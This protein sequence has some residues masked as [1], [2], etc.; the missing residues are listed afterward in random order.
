[1]GQARVAAALGQ[2]CL[3]QQEDAPGTRLAC[4]DGRLEGRSAPADHHDIGPLPGRGG[5]TYLMA[6]RHF[7]NRRSAIRMSSPTRMPKM[8]SRITPSITRSVRR[9]VP[10]KLM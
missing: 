9:V 8:P 10:E 2:G 3:L 4:G 7:S 5:A 6:G 1:M